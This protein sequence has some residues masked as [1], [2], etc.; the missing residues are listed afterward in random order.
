MQ[1]QS[2]YVQTNHM[3]VDEKFESANEKCEVRS[4][5]EALKFVTDNRK[6]RLKKSKIYAKVLQSRQAQDYSCSGKNVMNLEAIK[7]DL[8]NYEDLSII[9]ASPP[10]LRL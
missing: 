7:K 8:L 9:S 2:E 1:K 10:A 5:K 6:T 3:T 4:L